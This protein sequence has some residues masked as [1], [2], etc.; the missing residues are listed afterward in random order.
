MN[1]YGIKFPEAKIWRMIEFFFEYL[2]IHII[3]YS[4]Y[5]Y[6]GHD[7]SIQRVKIDLTLF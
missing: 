6:H 3:N 1:T 4:F 5:Q 2:L 7:Q